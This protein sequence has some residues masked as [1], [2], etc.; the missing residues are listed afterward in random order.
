MTATSKLQLLDLRFVNNSIDE[1]CYVDFIV[2]Q[3]KFTDVNKNN[4]DKQQQAIDVS[5]LLYFN[6]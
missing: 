5:Y 1:R 4:T 3:M 2:D 6:F